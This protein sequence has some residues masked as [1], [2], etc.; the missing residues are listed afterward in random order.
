MMNRNADYTGRDKFREPEWQIVDRYKNTVRDNM[1]MDE[2]MTSFADRIIELFELVNEENGGAKKLVNNVMVYQIPSE[3]PAPVMMLSSVEEQKQL[4][5]NNFE[6]QIIQDIVSSDRE[7]RARAAYLAVCL[8]MS[9]SLAR[10][11][12]KQWKAACND[13][14]GYWKIMENIFHFSSDSESGR[15]LGKKF[16]E[17][18]FRIPPIQYSSDEIYNDKAFW[19]DPEDLY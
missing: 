5:L 9:G 4:L 18:G 8:D 14:S 1:P 16:E 13:L 15:L 11:H 19:K 7:E 2:T 17:S 10:S 12:P 3:I 6:K